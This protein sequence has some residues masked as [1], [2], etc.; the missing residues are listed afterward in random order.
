MWRSRFRT[1]YGSKTALFRLASQG[2]CCKG[3]AATRFNKLVPPMYAIDDQDRVVAFAGAPP[4]DAGAPMPL[5]VANEW[6]LFLS[7]GLAPNSQETAGL[8][9]AAAR[10]HYFG[11]P[12]D[13]ALKGHP[14]WAR[15]LRWYGT[16]EVVGSSWI[17]S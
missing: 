5:L 17:R 15:G 11:P 1:P 4:A 16:F 6:N 8:K 9:F 13:E 3:R 12:N 7:Y 10:T 2:R 14:L